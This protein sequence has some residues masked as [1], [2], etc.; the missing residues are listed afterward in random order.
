MLLDEGSS[1]AD[2]MEI[3]VEA[4]GGSKDNF[5]ALWSSSEAAGAGFIIA[6]E[7]GKVF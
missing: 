3:L 4:S 5:N 2:V 6:D 1:L 7:N